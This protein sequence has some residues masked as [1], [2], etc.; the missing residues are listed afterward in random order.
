MSLPCTARILFC[1]EM[2]GTMP[3]LADSYSFRFA[4]NIIST[5]CSHPPAIRSVPSV[6]GSV[7]PDRSFGALH[8]AVISIRSIASEH[9]KRFW[10]RFWVCTPPCEVCTIPRDDH[11]MT[12]HPQHLTR[13][14]MPNS[15]IVSPPLQPPPPPPPSAI[16]KL[17]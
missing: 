8:P 7:F 1:T 3:T 11:T 4:G 14:K 15:H 2:L 16:G 10:S 12:P 6:I 17:Q 9:R 13:Q 5:A